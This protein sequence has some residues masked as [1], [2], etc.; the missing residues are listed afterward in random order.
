MS[1]F[2]DSQISGFPDFRITD[3]EFMS[4]VMIFNRRYKFMFFL[5]HACNVFV[6]QAT[7]CFLSSML[8]HVDTRPGM[9]HRGIL[10]LLFQCCFL[11]S[12]QTWIFTAC[13]CFFPDAGP[14]LNLVHDRN[15]SPDSRRTRSCNDVL[16]LSHACH[17][18][19]VLL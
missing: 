15:Q 14:K 4:E 18:L 8:R 5:N 13:V 1:G 7:V 6:G 9:L 16:R 19:Y 17:M 11:Y 3:A 2:S 10:V 12:T